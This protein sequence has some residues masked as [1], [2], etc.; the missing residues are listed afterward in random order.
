LDLFFESFFLINGFDS[1]DMAE[2][3]S[4][5]L[6]QELGSRKVRKGNDDRNE[7]WMQRK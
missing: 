1:W 4:R 3:R 7:V 5:T 2:I 6:I